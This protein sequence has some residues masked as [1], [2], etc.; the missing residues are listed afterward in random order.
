[1]LG[2]KRRRSRRAA[3]PPLDARA[4]DLKGRKQ[5]VTIY[6][7]AYRAGVSAATVSRVLRGRACVAE[8]KRKAVMAAA[9]AL[10]YRPNLMAKDLASGRSQ[11][12][13]MV[14]PDP[15]S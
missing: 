7:I 12:V 5:P 8:A 1:M 15:E 2:P 9:E 13:G 14:L 3:A 11:T 10:R 6:D 4:M